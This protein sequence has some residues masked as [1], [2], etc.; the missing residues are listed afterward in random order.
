VDVRQAWRTVN[1]RF[2]FRGSIFTFA[3]NVGTVALAKHIIA[4]LPSGVPLSSR[5]QAFRA[6]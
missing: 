2:T 5:A 1:L 6:T 3:A 4:S